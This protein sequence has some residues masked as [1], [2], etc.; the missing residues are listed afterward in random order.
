MEKEIRKLLTEIL[1]IT[2]EQIGD[3]EIHDDLLEYELDSL[4]AIELIVNLESSFDVMIDEEDLLIDNLCSIEK[5]MN[6]VNKYL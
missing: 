6:V 3:I 4:K 5:I 1:E 2:E